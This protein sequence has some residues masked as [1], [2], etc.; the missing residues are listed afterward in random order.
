MILQVFKFLSHCK[1]TN[2]QT[3]IDNKLW[4]FFKTQNRKCQIPDSESTY[5]DESL[6]LHQQKNL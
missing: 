1:E 3:S 5:K 6:V 4:I 2:S